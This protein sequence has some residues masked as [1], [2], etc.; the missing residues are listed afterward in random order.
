VSPSLLL[1]LADHQARQQ[2]LSIPI[3][4]IWKNITIILIAYGEVLWFGGSVTSLTLA[5]FG[6]MVLSSVL[7][8]WADVAAALGSI[9]TPDPFA[10][11][12]AGA[13]L[14][15]FNVGYFWMM[16]NCI[17][18]ASY[19]LA[20]RKRIKI[21]NFKDWDTLFY[22]NLLSIPVLV[23]ATLLVE[24]WTWENLSVNL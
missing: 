18:T 17:A 3:Y 6:L 13:N 1:S 19:V 15:E 21:T 12:P 2:Y 7:A 4:T 8:A 24:N 14:G 11:D 16:L 20:M 10:S 22:N 23:V 5:S 9:S